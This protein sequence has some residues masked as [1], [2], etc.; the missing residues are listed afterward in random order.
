MEVNELF[1][2]ELLTLYT[3]VVSPERGQI[4]TTGAFAFYVFMDQPPGFRKFH[5]SFA[6]HFLQA[7]VFQPP[8]QR[9]PAGYE[10]YS[11]G[12][13]RTQHLPV[14]HDSKQLR[15]Q[16]PVIY[17]ESQGFYRWPYQGARHEF[18][19]TFNNPDSSS[20]SNFSSL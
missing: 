3:T 14:R 15:M 7:G 19:I 8:A 4:E 12:I 20:S 1:R 5:V 9:V 17:D 13:S 2:R 6:E 18:P 16:G 11:Q 10:A